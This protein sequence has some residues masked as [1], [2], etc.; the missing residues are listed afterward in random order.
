MSDSETESDKDSVEA[1]EVEPPKKK[2]RPPMSEE[3]RKKMLENLA[4]DGQ[5]QTGESE[6]EK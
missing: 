2:T 3:R 6:G 4:K 5:R 1:V